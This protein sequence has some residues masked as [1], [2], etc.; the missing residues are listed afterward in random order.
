MLLFM[1]EY[2]IICLTSFLIIFHQMKKKMQSS[3]YVYHCGC[4]QGAYEIGEAENVDRGT[5]I[6]IHL[7]G[8]C[9]DFA[10]EEMIRGEVLVLFA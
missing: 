10:K 3:A 9:Y 5:K 8:D 4:R 7:K 6:V 1:Y 2:T